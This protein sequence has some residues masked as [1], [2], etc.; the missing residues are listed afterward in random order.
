M[1]RIV[2]ESGDWQLDPARSIEESG[3]AVF[4]FGKLGG[5]ELNYSSDIDLLALF[6]ADKYRDS[7]KLWETKFSRLMELLRTHLA[8]RT[9]SGFV[10]RVD[11]RL[12]PYGRSGLLAHSLSSMCD[13]YQSTAS[14]WEHQALI[15]LRPVAGDLDFGRTALASLKG[16]LLRKSDPGRIGGG[17]RN[18][19][20]IAASRRSNIPRGV[21]IKSGEG[22]IRDIEF[23]IQGLQ[24]IHAHQTPEVLSGNTLQGLEKLVNCRILARERGDEIRSDYLYLRRVEHFLQL[25]DDRQVHAV[26]MGGE[27]LDALARRI[28]GKGEDPAVFVRKIEATMTRV[29][30][31]FNELLP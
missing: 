7:R 29:R 4:A 16:F 31:A 10:Y 22:G 21:D 18:Q 6:D 26:P 28:E 23:L 24:L 12:R 15:R 3:F 14:D 19:R 2:V 17:I 8:D 13:Y 30:A 5:E 20:N 25:L 9:E 1:W 27:A 11:F